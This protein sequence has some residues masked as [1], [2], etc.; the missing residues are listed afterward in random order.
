MSEE[1]SRWLAIETLEGYMEVWPEDY[2]WYGCWKNLVKHL[3]KDDDT[4]N[5]AKYLS[6]IDLATKG[7]GR[8]LYYYLENLEYSRQYYSIGMPIG[9][10]KKDYSQIL[11]SFKKI[12]KIANKSEELKNSFF[13]PNSNFVINYLESLT[14]RRMTEVDEEQ[15]SKIKC[16]GP[17]YNSSEEHNFL[18][19]N[20]LCDVHIKFA[21]ETLD[22]LNGMVTVRVDEDFFKRRAIKTLLETIKEIDAVEARVSNK[23]HADFLSVFLNEPVT[24][25]NISD[26]KNPKLNIKAKKG[27]ISKNKN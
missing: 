24:P 8:F 16:F 23:E 14:M 11:N 7:Y 20:K 4:Y 2:E 19:I 6:K 9:E 25:D 1:R 12:K 15:I 3:E 26:V 22:E 27:V 13:N 17:S 21:E 18:T 5:I 10:L